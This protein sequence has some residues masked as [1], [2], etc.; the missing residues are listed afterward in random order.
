MHRPDN[1]LVILLSL[2]PDVLTSKNQEGI[3]DLTFSLIQNPLVF[4][5]HELHLLKTGL[6]EIS[7][8]CGSFP[9]HIPIKC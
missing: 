7:Q 3:D 8:T 6:I 2:S 5:F 1:I 9:H 4:T